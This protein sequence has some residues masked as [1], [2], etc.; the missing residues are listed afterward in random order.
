MALPLRVEGDKG[1][2]TKKKRPF[3]EALRKDSGKNVVASKLEG[4]G[5]KALVA[6]PLKKT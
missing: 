1:L 3:F 5:A 6:G 4:G 2:A